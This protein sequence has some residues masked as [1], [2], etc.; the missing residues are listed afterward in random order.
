M[1]HL[2]PTGHTANWTIECK[3]LV[4]N[5]EDWSIPN[6]LE[7]GFMPSAL[8]SLSNLLELELESPIS[9][10]SF[11]SGEDLFDDTGIDPNDLCRYLYNKPAATCRA[12]LLV[13]TDL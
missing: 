4:Y 2:S 13:S 10:S 9:S 8:P 12:S 7:F 5:F 11:T 3:P 6:D 1:V